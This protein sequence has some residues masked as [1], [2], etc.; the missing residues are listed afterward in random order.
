MGS[1]LDKEFAKGASGRTLSKLEPNVEKACMAECVKPR[2]NISEGID[3]EVDAGKIGEKCSSVFDGLKDL[4]RRLLI[5]TDVNRV[6]V[7]QG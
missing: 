7:F 5:E 6:E 1:E 2:L 4:L 3:G